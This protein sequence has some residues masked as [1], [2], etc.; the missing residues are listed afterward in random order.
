[1][2]A[3]PILL[4]ETLLEETTG[5]YT[6]ELVDEAGAGVDGQFLTTLTLTLYD[7]DSD[8]IVNGRQ[9]QNILNT[10]GGTV[11]TVVGPPL[12]TTVTVALQPEDSVIFNPNRVAEYR[13]LQCRWTWDSGQRVGA[14]AVQFGIENLGFVPVAP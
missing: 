9:D 6:F 7:L 8:Q 5:T 11:Q 10:N 4:T 3:T 13:V 12:V 14:H 1:M 2:P